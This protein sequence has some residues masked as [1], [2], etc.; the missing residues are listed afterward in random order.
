MTGRRASPE[1]TK[2]PA[3][4]PVSLIDRIVRAC[5]NPQDLLLDPFMGSGTVAEVAIRRGR[6]AI[7]FEIKA[8]YLDIAI[9][10]LERVIHTIEQEKSQ[11][12]LL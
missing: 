7:G 10:R 2:H 3:Q 9:E 4:F 8:E 12:I 6:N 5:S 11:G 1:R